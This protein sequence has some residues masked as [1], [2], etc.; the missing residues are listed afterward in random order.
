MIDGWVPS[1]ERTDID[2]SKRSPNHGRKFASSVRLLVMHY[3][4]G[5]SFE[6]SVEHLRNPASKAS[7]HFVVA[8]DGRVAQLVSLDLVA[9]HAGDSEWNG[10]K[11]CNK[12]SIGIE[13]D[14]FGKLQ[15]R[16]AGWHTWW[17]QLVSDAEVALD[18]AGHGWHAY[19][20]KQL[21]SAVRL[22][23]TI[24]AYHPHIFEIVGH[25]DIAPS[26]KTD[27]GPAFPMEWYRT[28]LR[29]RS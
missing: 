22:G 10:R 12:F 16:Q 25:Q 1:D 28:M 23:R 15:K 14:N 8:R 26:R 18:D 17:G 21:D 11:G 24:L 6:R 20:V 19:D 4:A 9:W 29:G 13:L 3:T 5:R 7:A 2:S 27:P